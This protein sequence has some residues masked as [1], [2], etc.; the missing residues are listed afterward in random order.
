MSTQATLV[1]AGLR[2][3]LDYLKGERE[4][5]AETRRGGFFPSN[6]MAEIKQ[7]VWLTCNRPLFIDPHGRPYPDAQAVIDA[8]I[9]Y[10]NQRGD[11]RELD[12]LI[13]AVETIVSRRS[14]AARME[15]NPAA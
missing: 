4:R 8:N 15:G 9:N 12:R 1:R 7:H 3:L 5:I 10:M 13:R 11:P 6:A 14:A 2:R